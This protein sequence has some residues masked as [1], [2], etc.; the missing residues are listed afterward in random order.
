MVLQIS[1]ISKK[2]IIITEKVNVLKFFL[3]SVI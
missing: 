3:K 1:V 2:K